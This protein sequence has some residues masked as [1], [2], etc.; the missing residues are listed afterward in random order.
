MFVLVPCLAGGLKAGVV[1]G[2]ASCLLP[3]P[4][5]VACQGA[6]VRR[7]RKRFAKRRAVRKDR[8]TGRA[9]RDA[10]QHVLPR[11]ATGRKGTGRPAGNFRGPGAVP[12]QACARA[13]RALLRERGR[14]WQFPISP[15]GLSCGFLGRHAGSA[16]SRS[17][18]LWEL[19]V[20]EFP[21]HEKLTERLQSSQRISKWQRGN[22]CLRNAYFCQKD[23]LTF[24]ACDSHKVDTRLAQVLCPGCL[25]RRFGAEMKK[26]RR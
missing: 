2:E 13:A 24:R 10:F 12:F 21:C 11:A 22:R 23:P 26:Q 16:E 18:R 20:L 4:L 5:I 14:G 15:R 9:G 3:A 7:L 25:C 1:A 8:R 19:A 6:R 17:G